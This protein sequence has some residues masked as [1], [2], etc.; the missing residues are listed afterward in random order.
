MVIL[1][2][3]LRNLV[4]DL[5]RILNIGNVG[6]EVFCVLMEFR[7]N[8]FLYLIYSDFMWVLGEEF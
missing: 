7:I 1:F 5:Y 2:I 8:K 6:R 3:L 4:L